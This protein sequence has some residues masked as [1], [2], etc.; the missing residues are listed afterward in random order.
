MQ[1]M[2]P[3][4]IL[5]GQHPST[6][7]LSRAYDH[8]CASWRGSAASATHG[9]GLRCVLRDV[10]LFLS[11][12]DAPGVLSMPH[13]SCQLSLSRF[14]RA[15]LILW[16]QPCGMILWW[17]RSSDL[18]MDSEKIGMH[19]GSTAKRGGARERA[20]A[21]GDGQQQ[22]GMRER[23]GSEGRVAK[24]IQKYDGWSERPHDGREGRAT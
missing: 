15:A 8:V 24:Y 22:Q 23:D 17:A 9:R 5:Y 12:L 6:L 10:L 7:R 4:V 11:P 20:W 14:D 16:L 21:G 1:G 18:E 13:Q 19:R 3:Q 2:S